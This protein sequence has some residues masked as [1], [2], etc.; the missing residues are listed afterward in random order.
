MPKLSLAVY[1]FHQEKIEMKRDVVASTVIYRFTAAHEIATS[2]RNLTY[3]SRPVYAN[4]K[5]TAIGSLG[6]NELLTTVAANIEIFCTGSI[7]VRL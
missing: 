3:L 5:V 4:C 6:R 1:F 7:K 2:S